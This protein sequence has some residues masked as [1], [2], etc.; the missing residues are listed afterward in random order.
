MRFVGQRNNYLFT[1]CWR[2]LVDLDE[3]FGCHEVKVTE[4][5]SAGGTRVDHGE[6]FHGGLHIR[7]TSLIYLLLFTSVF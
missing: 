5:G 3:Y 2:D 7:P 1:P 6:V 4:L